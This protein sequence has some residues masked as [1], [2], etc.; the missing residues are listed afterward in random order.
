MRYPERS[1]L[2]W[3]D[4]LAGLAVRSVVDGGMLEL[5]CASAGTVEPSARLGAMPRGAWEARGSGG[6][7]AIGAN[8]GRWH[9]GLTGIIA[10]E[11]YST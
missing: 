5:T 4:P 2:V 3:R 8:A 1:R 7:L 6:I 9:S 11:Y 10:P